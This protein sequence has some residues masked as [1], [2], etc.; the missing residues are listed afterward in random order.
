MHS[1]DAMHGTSNPI[2]EPR[3]MIELRTGEVIAEVGPNGVPRRAYKP[4]EV[5][6]ILGVSKRYVYTLI[7]AGELMAVKQA[8]GRLQILSEDLD[9]FIEVLKKERE[10]AQ[11]AA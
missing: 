3:Q 4:S 5:A 8:N 9:A 6:E 7:E 2:P 10:K 11:G 1:T